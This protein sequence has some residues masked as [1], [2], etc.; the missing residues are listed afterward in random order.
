MLSDQ[1]YFD[2]LIF[3]SEFPIRLLLIWEVSRETVVVVGS[4]LDYR[5]DSMTSD[6]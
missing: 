5:G 6:F 2:I 4:S 3:I 1:V